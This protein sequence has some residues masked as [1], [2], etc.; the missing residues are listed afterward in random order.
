MYSWRVI[1]LSVDNRT[2]S[3]NSECVHVIAARLLM[4]PMVVLIVT[5][6][7]WE[8][9]RTLTNTK[10]GLS[11]WLL[12]LAGVQSI[13]V[14]IDEGLEVLRVAQTVSDGGAVRTGNE[15]KSRINMY[16]HCGDL[17]T[18]KMRRRIIINSFS[19][20][21]CSIFLLI[22]ELE[23]NIFRKLKKL[24]LGNLSTVFIH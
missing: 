13:M 5:R 11:P 1:N 6:V 4:Q 21:L 12:F 7:A 22:D 18:W 24:Y 20:S 14:E 3:R 17:H 2:S 16:C 10:P 19:H 9:Q 23:S 8:G 15:S